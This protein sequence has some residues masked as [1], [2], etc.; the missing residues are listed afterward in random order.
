MASLMAGMKVVVVPSPKVV[1]R[2]WKD[3]L[4]TLPWRPLQASKIITHPMW[5]MIEEGQYC[6]RHGNTIFL[7]ENQ[8][9]ELQKLKKM[10]NPFWL[11]QP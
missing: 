10:E 2:T 6:Y 3:R 4:L 11:G 9:S 5:N 8:F 7:N 1:M